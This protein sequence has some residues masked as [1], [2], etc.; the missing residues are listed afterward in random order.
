MPGAPS[1]AITSSI[2]ILSRRITISLGFSAP[3]FDNVS[4]RPFDNLGVGQPFPPWREESSDNA[5][6]FGQQSGPGLGEVSAL[7]VIRIDG[8]HVTGDLRVLR[9]VQP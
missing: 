4:Q 9:L 7:P 8:W 6:C 1:S 3:A 2:V 5:P